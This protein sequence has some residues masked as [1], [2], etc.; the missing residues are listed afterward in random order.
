MPTLGIDAVVSPSTITISTVLRHVR[1]G[2]VA[3]VHTLREDF[4]EIVE[5]EITEGSRLY[6]RPL[7]Q[8][9]LP[10]GSPSCSSG[11]RKSTRLNSSHVAI[12]YDVFCL[13]KK[14][15]IRR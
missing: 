13:K 11:D 3:T 4:G 1:S 8:L 6:H 10:R 14:I 7:E 5:A 12:S 15:L 9:G 2:S